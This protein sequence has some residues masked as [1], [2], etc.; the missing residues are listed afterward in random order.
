MHDDDF[1]V[2]AINHSHEIFRMINAAR[3]LTVTRYA[4]SYAAA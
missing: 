3:Y 1:M 2:N 4:A